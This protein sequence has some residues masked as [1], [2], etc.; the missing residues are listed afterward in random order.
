MINSLLFA[1]VSGALAA[2]ANNVFLNYTTVKGYFLQDDP[3][4]NPTGFD[5]VSLF[6]VM[7]SEAI[8]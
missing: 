4:T 2:P 7:F 5:Y 3:A 8:D 1:L 6:R